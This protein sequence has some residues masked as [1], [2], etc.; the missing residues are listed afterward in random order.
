MAAYYDFRENPNPNPE[1]NEQQLLHPRLVLKETISSDDMAKEIAYSSSLTEGDLKA[2][3]SA[4]SERMAFYLREGHPVE[5]E[6]I[7][8]FSATIKSRSVADRKEIRAASISFSGVN[9]RPSKPFLGDIK[10]GELL[11]ATAGFNKSGN[12][13][14]EE[15]IAMLKEYLKEKPFISRSEY[16]T[17]TGRLRNLA[18]NDLKKWV[19]KGYLKT[20]GRRSTIVYMK[21]DRYDE[22]SVESGK[23]VDSKPEG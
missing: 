6:G 2:A 8:K 21:G 1:N 19:K 17:L 3:I 23:D 5:L 4:L 12:A 7:G 16:T 13:T 10:S 15:C 22:F 20:H 18:L 14:P 11:R 9:F